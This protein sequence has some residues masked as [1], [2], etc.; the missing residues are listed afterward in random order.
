MCVICV[1]A[2]VYAAGY[3]CP[4]YKKYTSCNSGFYLNGTSAGNACVS[5]STVSFTDSGT[6]S[7]T[8]SSACTSTSQTVTSGY[9]KQNQ[10]RSGSRTGTRTK[11]RTCYRTGGAGGTNGASACTGAGNCGG[12]TY[13]SW[14]YGSCSYTAWTNSGGLHSCSCPS[15][16][17]LSGT[18]CP[19]CTSVSFTDSGTDTGTDSSGCTAT[20]QTV[21]VN[22][23]N[24]S[25]KQN[26]TRSGSRS[27]SRA[28][29]RTCYRTGGAGGT[30]GA[31]ACTGSGNCGG[32]T[33]G[34]YSYGT[35]SYTTWTNSGGGHS[36]SCNAGYYWNGSGCAACTAGYYC[37]G[38]SNVNSPASGYGRN[39]CT[40]A[41]ANANYTGSATTNSCAWSCKAGYYGSS[42]AGSTSCADCGSGNY[43]T[44]GTHRATCAST[45]KAGS[46]TPANIVSLSNGS[47]SDKNHGASAADCICDWYFS[48]ETRTQYMNETTCSNG[49]GG[50]NYTHY[51]W[52]RT[53]YY[54]S[55]PLNFNS[56]YNACSA[57][58]NKPANATYTGRGTPST[59]YAVENNCPWQCNAN[60]Y[61]NNGAC[62]ACNSG[63]TSPA[64]TT[65]ASG[66]T[67]SCTRACTQQT[68][69]ASAHTCTHGATSTTG[70]DA[71]G[72]G[73]NAAQSTCSLTINSCKNGYYKDGNSCKACPSS[74]PNS[75]DGTTGSSGA[76]WTSCG[77]SSVS[78]GYIPPTV[79]RVN[80]PTVCTYNPASTVCNT[81][82]SLTSSYVCAA[83][84]AAGVTKIRTGNVTVPLYAT[85]Q[86]S[87]ALHIRVGNQVCYGS[88]GANKAATAVNLNYGGNTY[89]TIK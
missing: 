73:C 4:T 3:S 77:N 19:S 67:K 37:P 28:K 39:S 69:P 13:G 47:W 54:A 56:W 9:C 18:S 16:S 83:M 2:S 50:S 20:S 23:S 64:G 49:P 58:T 65:A 80:Y 74:H 42:G 62:T 72:V 78:N 8:D 41:P 36:Y 34:N 53:G 52:C 68:C 26:Q 33:Y 57:C 6:E 51:E 38:F 40:N 5:C 85:K 60:Y 81:G 66:C 7:T 84:C 15:G 30:N 31:S 88:L 1:P 27:W 79:A 59:M 43:C 25:Y 35:C 71:Q 63:Y 44:G 12:Y 22:I 17:Y 82:H 11:S 10:V 87:P 45:V 32:Y 89:H 86:T 29:S 46:P 76:C 61:A 14:S 48:D 70:T 55:E 75:A 24:G 21:T